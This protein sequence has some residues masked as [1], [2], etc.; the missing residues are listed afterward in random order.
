MPRFFFNDFNIVWKS[1]KISK[2]KNIKYK[3]KKDFENFIIK[4]LPNYIP[5]E[6]IENYK[7]INYQ[8]KKIKIKSNKIVVGRSL[9]E[10]TIK[11]FWVASKIN[12]GSK[13][14]IAEHGGGH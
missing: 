10:N 13:L 3:T 9:W 5:T 7:I 4:I 11:K 14:F 6:F 12:N 8:I 2:R 1:H